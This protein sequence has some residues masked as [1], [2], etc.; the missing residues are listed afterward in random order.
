MGNGAAGNGRRAPGTRPPAAAAA[1]AWYV[2]LALLAGLLAVLVGA[3][4]EYSL[5]LAL[6]G[7]AVYFLAR[8]RGARGARATGASSAEDGEPGERGG[9]PLVAIAVASILMAGYAGS[10][11]AEASAINPPTDGVC[12]FDHRPASA[13]Y[14]RTGANGSVVQTH[15]FCDD[16]ILSFLV[17]HPLQSYGLASRPA[18]EVT[19]MDWPPAWWARVFAGLWAAF[20]SLMVLASLDVGSRATRWDPVFVLCSLRTGMISMAT[21]FL[22]TVVFMAAAVGLVPSLSDPAPGSARLAALLGGARS[23]WLLYLAMMGVVI[24]FLASFFGQRG[25]AV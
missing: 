12:D 7:A 19:F 22:A 3:S 2:S 4:G 11:Y 25:R 9:M 13:L 16:H 21:G 8:Y 24:A 14:Q 5:A 23:D 6:G 15:E 10:F 18:L 17:L 20:I 1:R